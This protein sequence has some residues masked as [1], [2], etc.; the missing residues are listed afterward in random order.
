MANPLVFLV[1]DYCPSYSIYRN[2]VR[3]NASEDR[4]VLYSVSIRGVAMQRDACAGC[5]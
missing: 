2:A 1:P 4:T 5:L 3:T